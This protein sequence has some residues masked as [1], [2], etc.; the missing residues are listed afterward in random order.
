MFRKL[1]SFDEAKQLL[2]QSFSPAPVGIEQV[3]ISDAHN[4]ILAQD[5]VAPMDIPPFSR[6]TVD[7]YA[8]K[9]ADTFGATEDKDINLRV[10]GHVAIGEAPAVVVK[11]G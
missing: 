11:K 6:S 4:R 7:G 10:C 3:S 1:L 2:E 9:A 5:I 8:V